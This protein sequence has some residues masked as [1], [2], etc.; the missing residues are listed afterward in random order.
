MEQSTSIMLTD[1]DYER[2]NDLLDS[3]PETRASE[4]SSLRNELERAVIVAANKIPPTVVTMNSEVRCVDESSGKEH[5][6]TLVFPSD[7]DA[8]AGRISVLAP[9]GSALI[10]LSV[11]QSI[12]WQIKDGRLLRLKVLHV[13]QPMGSYISRTN[14]NAE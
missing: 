8:D 14:Q 1:A 7:A 11:G 12:H 4:F 5:C 6:I 13:K 2:L 9:L 10:G 3:L